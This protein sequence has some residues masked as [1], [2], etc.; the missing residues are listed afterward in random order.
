MKQRL[1]TVAWRPLLGLKNTEGHGRDVK[2]KH[3]LSTCQ[4]F[5]CCP[6]QSQ[7]NSVDDKGFNK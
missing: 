3:I 2:F 1:E 6:S 5:L 7:L 4:C